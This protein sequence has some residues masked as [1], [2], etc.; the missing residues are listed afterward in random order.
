MGRRGGGRRVGVGKGLVFLSRMDG[1][2]QG[3]VAGMREGKKE[4]SGYGLN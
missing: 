4:T 1:G 3:Q 2:M